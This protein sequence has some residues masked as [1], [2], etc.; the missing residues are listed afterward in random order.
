MI[1]I[2]IEGINSFPLTQLNQ[3]KNLWSY[4]VFLTFE[5]VDEILKPQ[6]NVLRTSVANIL[7]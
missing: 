5:R 1:F 6:L 4:N 3:E 2:N 7:N